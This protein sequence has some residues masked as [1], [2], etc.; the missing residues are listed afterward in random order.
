[1]THQI[2]SK[3]ELARLTDALE[4]KMQKEKVI[5]PKIEFFM[6]NSVFLEQGWYKDYELQEIID[7]ME[8]KCSQLNDAD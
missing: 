7:F 5:P 8:E 2:M 3:E 4:E 6:E 1:M